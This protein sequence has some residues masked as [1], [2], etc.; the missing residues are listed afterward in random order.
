MATTFECFPHLPN[1]LKAE[2]FS[3]ALHEEDRS[4]ILVVYAS[5]VMPLKSLIS[6]LLSVNALSRKMA[7]EHY[8]TK[9]DIFAV[10]TNNLILRV[11]DLKLPDRQSFMSLKHKETKLTG[12]TQMFEGNDFARGSNYLMKHGYRSGAGEIID[13]EQWWVD[14]CI[15]K[16]RD[17]T[18]GGMFYR[19]DAT[20]SQGTLYLNPARN[21]IL[22]GHDPYPDF[23]S[24]MREH[25]T[26]GKVDGKGSVLRHVSSRLP[27]S[28]FASLGQQDVRTS[29][30]YAVN[31]P[32]MWSR[33]NQ[34]YALGIQCPGKLVQAQRSFNNFNRK[35]SIVDKP[36]FAFKTLRLTKED[37]HNLM[38]YLST[39]PD[40]LPGYIECW[41]DIDLPLPV[42]TS[43]FRADPDNESSDDDWDSVRLPEYEPLFKALAWYRAEVANLDLFIG[44]RKNRQLSLSKGHTKAAGQ[45]H[46]E[47]VHTEEFNRAEEGSEDK[48]V[49]RVAP[50][51]EDYEGCGYENDD[52]ETLYQKLDLWKQ[53]IAVLEETEQNIQQVTTQRHEDRPT[54]TM[55]A[56][57]LDPYTNWPLEF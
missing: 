17:G 4:R 16:M 33:H 47:E 53:A 42:D 52:L 12:W 36:V 15:V 21:T 28:L 55:L 34:Y 45:D 7:K 39:S 38:A 5:R 32:V 27:E 3:Y 54:A 37:T 46:G 40:N 13:L 11:S 35:P 30:C 43:E 1:E 9:L 51:F 49:A 8:T 31:S 24:G 26:S 29:R 2:I 22:Y 48:E 6:P 23:V 57:A 44:L 19:L 10:P 56:P 25:L 14:Q 50:K 18:I 20:I 41:A